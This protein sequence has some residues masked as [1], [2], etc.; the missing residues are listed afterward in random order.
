M[1]PDSDLANFLIGYFIHTVCNVQGKFS[2]APIF[3]VEIFAHKTFHNSFSVALVPKFQAYNSAA[4]IT[5]AIAGIIFPFGFVWLWWSNAERKRLEGKI[6][7]FFEVL[8]FLKVSLE[9][10]ITSI[11]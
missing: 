11:L 9:T 1:F 4:F 7:S 2:G 6:L 8:K 3:H 10:S 5:V